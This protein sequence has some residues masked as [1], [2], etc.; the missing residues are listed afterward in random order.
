M[1]RVRTVAVAVLLLSAALPVCAQAP[2]APIIAKNFEAIDSSTTASIGGGLFEPPDTNGAVGLQNYVQFNNGAFVVFRKDGS[3]VK[4]V[5]VGSFFTSAGVSISSA[6][7]SDPRLLYDSVNQRWIAVM[8]ST[9]ETVN[10]RIIISRSDTSDPA[11]TWKAVSVTAN[12]ITETSGSDPNRFA[13]YPTLGMTNDNIAIGTIN[14][15]PSG[16]VSLY[17]IPKADL[18]QTSPTTANLSSFDRNASSGSG[19]GFLISPTV[20]YSATSGGTMPVLGTLISGGSNIR[21]TTVSGVGAAGATYTGT[22]GSPSVQITVNAYSTP[23][24]AQQPGSGNTIDTIDN[25]IGSSSI[26]EGNLIYSVFE[27]GFNGRSAVR[28]TVLNETNNGVVFQTTLSESGADY[29]HPSVA[30]NAIGDVVIGFG[31]TRTGAN[32]LFPGGAVITGSSPDLATWNFNTATV[33]VAGSQSY[34]GG[35]WGDY[36]AT[37]PDQA[38][39]GIFW[40]TQEFSKND[41]QVDWSTQAA[42][43]ILPKTGE[44]RWKTTSSGMYDSG[45]NWFSGTAPTATDHVIVSRQSSGNY[46]LTMPTGDTTAD[47]LSV[48]QG[49]VTVSIP[50]GSSYSL[51]NPDPAKPGLSVV[52]FAGVGSL[53]VSGG[54]TMNTQNAMVAGQIGGTGTLTISGTGTIWNNVAN[55]SVGGT[56]TASGGQGT[57]NVIGGATANVGGT[58]NLWRTD[59]AVNI[60]DGSTLAVAALTNQ[61]ATAPTVTIGASSNLN[62]TSGG[63]TTFSGV[64]A[65]SGNIIKD[66]G[67]TF[68]LT[69]A[70]TYSGNTTVNAGTLV[71]AGSGSLANSAIVHVGTGATLDVSGI[72]GGASFDGSRFQLAANQTLRG[73]GAVQGAVTVGVSSTIA[74]G[75]PAAPGALVV[76]GDLVMLP[77]ST[78]VA[79][80]NGPTPGT[81]HDQLQVNGGATLIF[82]ELNVNLGGSYLP[83]GTDKLFILVVSGSDP[84]IGQFNNVPEGA[85]I[86]VGGQFSAKVS[87][88]GDSATDSLTGGNDV[89]LYN[90]ISVPEPGTVLGLSAFGI[91]AVRV[92]RRRRS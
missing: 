48:R 77:T 30:V 49:Q 87:Y 37:T 61:A 21:R 88:L 92:I 7:L 10:N 91:F 86:G 51:T 50:G 56:A 5:N 75:T 1:S 36:S 17:S 65:G 25:R 73:G 62:I 8:I 24:N 19:P 72:T 11:G 47:R 2:P 9:N 22:S 53:T 43:I 31:I 46:T 32:S 39:P 90:F 54:G 52:E 74:P 58:L 33:L 4:Q 29:F 15:T 35:R 89:V 63:G 6:N 45:S 42:E 76:N 64:I 44:E 57:L 34:A 18:Y 55:V 13:D 80:L 28:F 12:S 82:P 84:I 3:L 41:G 79:K 20:D 67:G 38:D 78:F 71:L 23:P 70:N 59:S 83:A 26:H 68:T 40:T 69:G 16:T 27:T 14:F 60:S 81:G 85:V 66:G